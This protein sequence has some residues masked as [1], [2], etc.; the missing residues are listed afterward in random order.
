MVTF[1]LLCIKSSDL[2]EFT[3]NVSKLVLVL[4]LFCI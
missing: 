3:K 4:L 2:G 1:V